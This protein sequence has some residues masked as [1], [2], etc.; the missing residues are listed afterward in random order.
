MSLDT[1]VTNPAYLLGRLLAVADS[2]QYLSDP[3]IQRSIR[4]RFLGYSAVNDPRVVFNTIMAEKEYH[5]SKLT[6][7][8]KLDKEKTLDQIASKLGA[9]PFKNRFTQDEQNMFFLGFY[10]QREFNCTRSKKEEE[11][12]VSAT[13]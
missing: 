12:P 3:D 1:N 7:P 10:H 4:D 11:K 5:L 13:E 6:N 2:I 8:C 9:E